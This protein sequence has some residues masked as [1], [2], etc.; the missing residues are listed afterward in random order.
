VAKLAPFQ[1][2]AVA[3]QVRY[4]PSVMPPQKENLKR[5]AEHEEYPKDAKVVFASVQTVQK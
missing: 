3:S 2:C 1:T 5:T 4:G